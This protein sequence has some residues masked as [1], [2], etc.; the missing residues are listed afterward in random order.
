MFVH[1]FFPRSV[2]PSVFQVLGLTG[3]ILAVMQLGVFPPLIKFVGIVNWQRAGCLLGVPVFL[4]V[5]NARFLSWNESSL[6]AVNV[7]TNLLAFCS[8]SSV[9]RSP[10][11]GSPFRELLFSLLSAHP[12]GCCCPLFVVEL[13]FCLFGAA[14]TEIYWLREFVLARAN[15]GKAQA[16]GARCC[17]GGLMSLRLRWRDTQ[18]G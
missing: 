11:E 2:A 17:L 3:I 6:F 4:A 18:L 8:I 13:F 14:C 1:A 15:R 12:S 16:G 10:E 9:R 7:L 5:P